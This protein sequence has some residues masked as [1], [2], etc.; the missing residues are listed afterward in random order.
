MAKRLW[1]LGHLRR[2]P[3]GLAI[4]VRDVQPPFPASRESLLFGRHAEFVFGA[5]QRLLA[6]SQ[7][8]SG[9]E[10]GVRVSRAIGQLAEEE[11]LRLVQRRDVLVVVTKAEEIA[12]VIVRLARQ[13]HAR[14]LDLGFR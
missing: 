11:V 12:A 5:P 7:R 2:W 1:G 3:S 14:G 4:F 10:D 8:A 9:P 13:A 6:D